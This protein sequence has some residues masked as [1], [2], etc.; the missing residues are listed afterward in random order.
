MREHLKNSKIVVVKVGTSTLT[1][2]TGKL[3]LKRV[4][5]LSRI[6]VDI[7]NSGKKVVLVS[8]GAVGVGM[9]KLQIN[10]RPSETKEKQAIAAVGQCELMSIYDRLFSEYGACVAQLLLTKEVISEEKFKTNVINT[11]E[12]LLE[13]D[14]VP[15]VNENDTISVDELTFGD[16]DTLSS[17]VARLVNADT[18][19]ILSDI[20]GLYTTNPKEDPDAK[21]ISCVEEITEEIEKMASGAGSARGTGG[22]HTKLSA[23]KYANEKGIDVII[24]NGRDPH[25]LY[26]ILEGK[27]T[28][29]IFKGKEI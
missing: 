12:T 11:F 28:G 27:E 29:T 1:Y 24:A 16:N 25:I 9:S 26:D 18:L 6:L 7:K 14:I 5:Q 13:K 22:M 19:I 17:I 10:T 23:A 15:I 2:E 8:S 21:V 4:D 3:N 20:D